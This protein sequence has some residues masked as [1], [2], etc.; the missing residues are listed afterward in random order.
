MESRRRVEEKRWEVEEE[1]VA[2]KLVW[3]TGEEC[4]FPTMLPGKEAQ[5]HTTSAD[6]FIL[7]CWPHFN[8][9][10]LQLQIGG[11][12]NAWGKW[13]LPTPTA[14]VAYVGLRRWDLGSICSNAALEQGTSRPEPSWPHLPWA[15]MEAFGP[16]KEKAQLKS[17]CYPPPSKSSAVSPFPESWVCRMSTL[18]SWK[19]FAVGEKGNGLVPHP[20]QVGQYLF[21]EFGTSCGITLPSSP[22]QVELWDW[23]ASLKMYL[24]KNIEGI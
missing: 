24:D 13:H 22:K 11:A 9:L 5:G 23:E 6:P 7:A 3:P 15:S 14:S 17:L 4:Q 1:K 8:Q 2:Q 21:S 16:K 20:W 19:G 12:K 18:E 10:E